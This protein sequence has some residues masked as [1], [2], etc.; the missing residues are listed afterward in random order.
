MANS[1]ISALTSASTPLAGTEVLPVVQSGVTKQVSVANLTA[2]RAVAGLSFTGTNDSSFNGVTV[3]KGTASIAGNTLVGTNGLLNVTTGSNLTGVGANA[4][5]GNTTGANNTAVGADAGYSQQAGN[6]N[7]L[8]G[9][10][11]GS[12][13]TAFDQLT[14]VG[15]RAGKFVEAN[16]NT[17]IGAYAGYYITTGAN[18]TV[19]GGYNGNQSSLDIR[20]SSGYIVLSDGLGNV[21]I[22]NDGTDWKIPTGNVIVGTAAKGINFTANT[23]ASGMTSQLLN[24]YEEG[25]W[26]PTYSP[27]SGAFTSV[28]YNT[29]TYGRYTRVGRLVTIQG[30][31]ITDALTLGTAAGNLRIA[32][33]PF[34]AAK[35]AAT[36]VGYANNFNTNNPSGGYVSGSV[37]FLTYRATANGV[38][39]NSQAGDLDTG[40]SF[41]NY[42]IFSTSYI[43]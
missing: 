1:K 11:T 3:G 22:Y 27:A 23:P 25:D 2:G 37:I 18:N 20:T 39:S 40:A 34:G 5:R 28:T 33:L 14:A 31:I 36:Y 41:R 21:R 4:L 10:D 24:W 17:L 15:F 26:T 7:T 32:G 6:G 30:I 8:L 42:L 19:L 9:S 12:Q 35:D 38:T 16:N 43:V 29:N 13:K